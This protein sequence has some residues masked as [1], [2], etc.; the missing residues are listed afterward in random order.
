MG[1][2]DEE[3]I[4]GIRKGGYKGKAVIGKDLDKY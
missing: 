4:E 3:L 1:A 2:T